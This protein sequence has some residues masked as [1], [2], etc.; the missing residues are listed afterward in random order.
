MSQSNYRRAVV[1]IATPVGW[2]HSSSVNELYG[3]SAEAQGGDV[4]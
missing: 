3:E 1:S 2:Q 4:M